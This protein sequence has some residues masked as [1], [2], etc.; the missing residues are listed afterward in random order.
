[1]DAYQNYVPRKRNIAKPAMKWKAPTIKPKKIK[2]S[3]DS[4]QSKPLEGVCMFG[5]SAQKVT[6]T[7]NSLPTM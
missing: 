1:M 3:A 5:S 4:N 2:F 7:K 6:E